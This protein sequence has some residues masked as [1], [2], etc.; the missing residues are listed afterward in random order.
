MAV[1]QTHAFQTESEVLP[2]ITSKQVMHTSQP[3]KAVTKM[4]L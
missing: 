3:R 4:K 1:M 2:Y